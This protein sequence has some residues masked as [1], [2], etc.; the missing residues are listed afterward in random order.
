MKRGITVFVIIVVIGLVC[1]SGCTSKNA[2]EQIPVQTIP[3][4]LVTA[5][6]KEPQTT[7]LTIAPNQTETTTTK[8]NTYSKE[9]P[10]TTLKIETAILR[11]TVSNCVMKEIF[12]TIANDPN[13][14]VRASPPK[15]SGISAGEWNRFIREYM[16]DKNE[17]S[18][19]IGI[20]RCNPPPPESPNN[21]YWNFIKISG[22]LIPRNAVPTNYEFVIHLNCIGKDVGQVRM[23]ETLD[24][25][26]PIQYVT[27]IAMRN[28]EMNLFNT[29]TL[30]FNQ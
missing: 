8:V 15:L 4:T 26:Q 2:T 25:N 30:E 12:P 17:N 23:N 29:A 20:S 11:Y 21:P 5:T 16:E 19:T 9:N 13:Y 14:G 3:T 27:Y 6:P 24:A 18:K 22:Q 28:D 1:I 10:D 7:T